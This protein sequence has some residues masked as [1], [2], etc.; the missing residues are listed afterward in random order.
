MIG[1]S[2]VSPAALLAFY[3]ARTTGNLLREKLRRLKEPR[4]LIGLVFGLGYFV[5][6]FLRPNAPRV[7]GRTG[8]PVTPEILGILLPAAA[9]ALA[10]LVLL[11]WL[12]RRGNPSLPLSEGEI[13]FLFPAPLPRRAVLHFALLRSQIGVFFS[14]FFVTLVLGRRGTGPP[15]Q[16]AVG[17]WLVFTALHFHFMAL[18]FTKARWAERTPAR[19]LAAKALT[20]VAVLAVLSVLAVTIA[21]GVRRAAD[22]LHGGR[23]GS[24]IQFETVFVTGPLGRLPFWLLLPFRWLLAPLF[25]PAPGFF[26]ASLPAAVAVALVQYVWVVRTNVSFE[27]ATLENAARRAQFRARREGGRLDALPSS[28]KRALVPF[29]LAA[30]GRPEIAVLWKNLLCFRRA[31]LARSGAFAFAGVVLLFLISA[32]ASFDGAEAVGGVAVMTTAA[33][34]MMLC[35]TLPMGLRIDL[36]GDLESADVLRLWPIPAVRLVAAELL[37]PILLSVLLLWAGLAAALAIALGQ[38]AR[39]RFSGGVLAAKAA[40]WLERPGDLLPVALAAALFLPALVA[41]IL[42]VQNAAVLTF[43]AWFSPGRKRAVGLEQT[44]MRLVSML[45]TVV[46]LAFALIPSGL[47]VAVLFFA[48]W[49]TLGIWTLPFAGALAALP[50]LAEAGAGV[51]F[52]AKLFER[53]D[54]SMERTG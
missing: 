37:A 34:T 44:G 42:V 49:K 31:S 14:S 28:R 20:A 16:T 8:L 40:P 26:L 12:F 54:P 35:V 43:P 19:R 33:L 24:L 10:V 17:L 1:A 7:R 46:L 23:L 50:L 30:A 3:L 25:A 11:G 13:Q 39:A 53:F 48:A 29:P 52:L 2:P 5:L 15:W 27:D 4:Y 38:V 9:T 36:R 45:A 41:L 51:F 21:D 18:G 32:A 47:L 6:V 22:G